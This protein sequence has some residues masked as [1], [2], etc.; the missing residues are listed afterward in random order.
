MTNLLQ[1][2]RVR[3]RVEASAL[4]QKVVWSEQNRR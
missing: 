3:N 1:K 2:L 4:A